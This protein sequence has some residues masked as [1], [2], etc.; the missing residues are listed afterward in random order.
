MTT[1]N[2]VIVKVDGLTITGQEESERKSMQQMERYANDFGYVKHPRQA[3]YFVSAHCQ[4]SELCYEEIC[5]T[6]KWEPVV[7]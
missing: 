7:R 2:W 5:D 6:K 1:Y 3:K 4:L